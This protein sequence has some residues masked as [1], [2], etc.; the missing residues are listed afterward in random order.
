[1]VS[2]SLF[3][4]LQELSL[5][6]N[7]LS[8]LASLCALPQLL[9]LSLSANALA[10]SPPL[11]PNAVPPSLLA[12]GPAAAA[13]ATAAATAAAA[14]SGGEASLP[15]A[16]LAQVSQ[17]L[18]RLDLSSNQINSLEGVPLRALPCLRV[19]RLGGNEVARLA[20]GCFEAQR[21]LLELDLSRCRLRAI[22][23]DALAPLISLIELR[24][25]ENALRSLEGLGPLPSLEL[26][27]IGSNRLADV[28]ELDR[29]SHLNCLRA[30]T[31]A[32]NPVCRKQLYRPTL[33]RRLAA[34]QSIDG[35][36][37]SVEE[38]ERVEL[39]FASEARI[40]VMGAGGAM[41]GGGVHGMGGVAKVALKLTAMSF[42]MLQPAPSQTPA[43]GM[44]HLATAPYTHHDRIARESRHTQEQ[45]VHSTSAR[46]GPV[47]PSSNPRRAYNG[48]GA[49][50]S[51]PDAH[52]GGAGGPF[53]HGLA[54]RRFA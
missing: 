13:A 14:A 46:K 51:A 23:P 18:E 43:P 40:N 34:L 11:P 25:D 12:R 37:I 27:S 29:L 8:S 30:V 52:G 15:L 20:R 48:P 31:C 35:R 53:G 42:D 49:S 41:G 24:L 54:G 22:D 3:S 10:S 6:Q 36:G 47:R 2:S 9:A 17:R 1:M 38:R 33:I 5:S 45:E 19:L 44:H 39:V 7:Q 32:A 21:H 16:R 26:L 4:S 50:S 28:S